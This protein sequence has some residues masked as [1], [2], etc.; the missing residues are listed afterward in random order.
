MKIRKRRGESEWTT[1]NRNMCKKLN[2]FD[3]KYILLHIQQHTLMT[4]DVA[5]GSTGTNFFAV[6]SKRESI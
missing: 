4:V 2:M 3:V 5:S 6:Y 1:S